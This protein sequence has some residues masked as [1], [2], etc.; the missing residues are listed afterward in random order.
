MHS[1]PSLSSREV[2]KI[3]ESHGFKLDRQVGS[4]QHYIGFIKGKTRL[5]TV[6]IGKEDF[7]PRTMSAMIR[8][9]GLTKE[10]WYRTLK[11]R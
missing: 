1:Y 9:S 6:I 11:K 4:H 8:Q 5:V 7:A 2:I 3:L 10:E